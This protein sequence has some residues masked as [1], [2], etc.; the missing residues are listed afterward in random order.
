MVKTGA[1]TTGATFF[2]AMLAGTAILLGCGDL[3]LES[4]RIPTELAV[5]PPDSGRFTVGE[6]T[7]LEFVVKD[8]HGEVLP[9]PSWVSPI[10]EA[11][12]ASVAD[13]SEEGTLTGKEIGWVDVTARLAG[14]ETHLN[15]CVNP[16]RIALS[17]PMI[18]LNQATQNRDGSVSLIAGRPALLRVFAVAD[19]VNCLDSPVRVT[20][21]RE[22][23]VVFEQLAPPEA[24]RISTSIDE[25]TL[26]GSYNVE[27]PGS[28]IQP[29][30]EMV[31]ELDPEGVLPLAPES[32][33]RYPAEGAMAL[34]VVELPVYR[35]ILVP[36]ISRPA[37]D[38]AVFDWV[39]GVNPESEQMRLG[40]TILPV[41]DMEVEVR[42]TYTTSLDLR[43]FGNWWYW[44]NEI[45]VLYEQEG[46]R[47]YYY[48]VVSRNLAVAG[49]AN[50]GYPVSVGSDVDYVY[51]HE[52]GHTMNL[53]H[54]PCGG[55]GGPDPRYPYENG[56]I[57]AWGYDMAERMLLDP[58]R[59]RDI[60]SYCFDHIW[61]SDYQFDRAMT[62]RLNGDGGINHDAETEAPP[63]LDR[64]EMLVVWGAVQEGRL[65][66]EPAFVLEGPVVLPESDGPY[67]VEGLGENGE[68][69]FSLSFS[70]VP[71]DH[72]GSSFPFFVPYEREWAYNLGRMVLTGPEGEYALT[73][74]GESEMAVLSDPATGRLRAIVRDWDGG[75]LPG[76]ESANVTVTRGIPAGGLR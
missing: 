23:D 52:V 17:A 15:Y 25:S 11:A 46:R 61:I 36:T 40:R 49:I 56:S 16:D 51:T 28:A 12:P 10:W 37:P 24:G 6:P 74:D 26:A 67:R 68:T 4:D 9:V 20:L 5:S 44:R 21:T 1:G 53:W 18:Y 70:P 62:H 54:A 39:D 43:Y 7:K 66:L 63:G 58:E 60:M 22:N 42:E 47:G 55:A 3:A 73:R 19:K 69:R 32:R 76:E 35:I 38:S 59:Y 8:Q 33:T 27:I 41:G 50:I 48:G 64:G 75:P 31:V 13:V 34:D 65:F 29:G 45:G 71:V 30:V 14:L 72:G 57:G 2:K